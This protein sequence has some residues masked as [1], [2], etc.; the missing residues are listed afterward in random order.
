MCVAS[1]W[2]PG[3]PFAPRQYAREWTL[4]VGI[5]VCFVA[6]GV[7]LVLNCGFLRRLFQKQRNFLRKKEQ[8]LFL[9]SSSSSLIFLV[10]F[11]YYTIY[12]YYYIMQ[13]ISTV[14]Q[15]YSLTQR[16]FSGFPLLQSWTSSA[17][18][19]FSGTVDAYHHRSPSSPLNHTSTNAA[20]TLRKRDV[21]M[22]A[23]PAAMVDP[24]HLHYVDW[25]TWTVRSDANDE[26]HSV[27]SIVIFFC[28][29]TFARL[30]KRQRRK[31]FHKCVKLEGVL[32]VCPYQKITAGAKRIIKH[33]IKRRVIFNRFFY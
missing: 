27:I 5:F 14:S 22:E 17:A 16:D 7:F 19:A 32:D 29:I 21:S 3:S 8:S 28:G 18:G 25:S 20:V 26:E 15:V 33:I 6:R 30:G 4:D 1:I 23:S 24:S 9:F 10:L 2:L 11:Y 13:F 31:E 12:A